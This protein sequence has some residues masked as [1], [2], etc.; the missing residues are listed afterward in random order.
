M[1]DEAYYEFNGETVADLITKYE[2]L[3][4]LRTC[5][6]AIGLAAAR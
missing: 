6:K 3:V 5:S 4:V 2:N 1:V